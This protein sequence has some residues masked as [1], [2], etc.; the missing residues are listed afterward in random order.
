MSLKLL[1]TSS[2]LFL[3]T[4]LL[5]ATASAADYA[6]GDLTVANPHTRA[7]PPG[8]RTAAG[9]AVIRNDGDTADRLIGGSAVFATITEV[10]EMSM[11]GDVMKMQHLEAGLEIPA[12]AE[13]TLKP[14]GLHMMYM[15]INQQL[16]AG[17]Q[18][19]ATFEFEKAGVVEVTMEIM[20]LGEKSH[21]A[22]DHSDK[23]MKHDHHKKSN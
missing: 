12:G 3:S 14:G 13:V 18:T 20:A 9:Y 1:C 16:M 15:Q 11:Q 17:E 7:T 10:H 4:V 6:I 19:T 5:Q 21:G 8:A 22:M 2:L 23:K